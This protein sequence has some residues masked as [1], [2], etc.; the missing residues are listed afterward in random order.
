[1]GRVKKEK[2]KDQRRER[3]RGKKLQA[4]EK[5]EKSRFTALF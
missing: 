5:I 3:V 1:V 4:R 2:K